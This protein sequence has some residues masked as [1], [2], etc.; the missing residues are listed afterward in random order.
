MCSD[1]FVEAQ[2]GNSYSLTD[3]EVRVWRIGFDLPS[4]QFTK[5]QLILSSDE[6]ERAERFHF[7][8]D[9]RRS[10]VARG[11]LRLLLG[12]ILG[13]PP[14]SLCFEYGEFGKP[15]LT[16]LPEH[17]VQFNVSHSGELILIA[18]AKGRAI[19]VDIERIRPDVDLDGVAVR[20]FSANEYRNLALLTGPDKYEGFFTCWTRKEAFLKAKGGGLSAPLDQF[21]VSL[22]PHQDARLLETRPDPDEAG[23]WKL[24][25]LP[26]P[27]GYVAAL[28][29]EG[30]DWTLAC[31][32]DSELPFRA[33][34]EF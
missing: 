4:A 10:V 16:N 29:A 22:L 31:F 30:R 9:F 18:I 21:D 24:V 1:D 32:G 13:V 28:A 2:T 34:E 23:R 15:R 12:Q 11:S 6:R 5:L 8:V 25:P 33:A 7:N 17:Q 19:G 14:K 3:N 27:A 20:F 26:A